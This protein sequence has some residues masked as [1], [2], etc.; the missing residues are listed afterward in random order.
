MDSIESQGDTSCF[1]DLADFVDP[2]LWVGDY[3]NPI[4]FPLEQRDA[5]RIVNAS[6]LAPFGLRT[7]TVVNRSVRNTWEIDANHFGLHNEGAWLA[8]LSNQLLRV[9][10]TLGLPEDRGI[11]ASPYKLLL[12]E[13]GAFFR[14]HTE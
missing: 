1:L 5:R 6:H 13:R 11:V 2:E 10:E 12:Y 9:Q 4:S 3:P 8:T 14:P 7:E